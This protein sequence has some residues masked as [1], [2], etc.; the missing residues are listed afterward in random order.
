MIYLTKSLLAKH[1]I[2]N[3]SPVL[4]LRAECHRGIPEEPLFMP[5][6]AD[7]GLPGIVLVN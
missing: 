6:A 2:G 3:C 7:G 4:E 5:G 1:D